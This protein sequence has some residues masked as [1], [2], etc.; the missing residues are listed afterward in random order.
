MIPGNWVSISSGLIG[1]GFG[2]NRSSLMNCGSI[3]PDYMKARNRWQ[4]CRDIVEGEDVVRSR[5]TLYLPK[6]SGQD[7]D[8]YTAY[9]LRASFTNGTGRAVDGLEGLIYRKKPTSKLPTRTDKLAADITTTGLTLDE[10]AKHVT[11]DV[12]KT[13]RGGLLVEFPTVKP[14]PNKVVAEA[15]S[16]GERP[17]ITYFPT[18]DILNWR[19]GKIKNKKQLTWLKL[20]DWLETANVDDP[21]ITEYTE[22]IIE[23]S[24]TPDGKCVQYE[25][26]GGRRIGGVPK[27]KPLI[28]NNEPLTYI[29]FVFVGSVDT[30]STV[31]K[32]LIYDIAVKN[33]HHWQLSADLRHALHWVDNPTPVVIGTI[34]TPDGRPAEVVKLGSSS[35]LNV[36]TGGDTK[37]LEMM[38]NGLEP[39]SKQMDRD[40][41][42]MAILLSRI[43]SGDSKAAE[44]AETAAI[45]RA[46]ENAVL[47]SFANAIS[48]AI[49]KAL[50][51]V[52]TWLKEDPT[53]VSYRLNT[54]FYPTPMTSQMLIALTNSLI[55]KAIS[56][57]EFFDTLIAGDVVRADK[58]IDEHKEEVAKMPDAEVPKGGALNAP[59]GADGKKNNGPNADAGTGS[60]EPQ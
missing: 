21:G 15:E 34:V 8:E 18:E 54:N 26:V 43:L 48:G 7:V 46:G 33:V 14:D 27:V 3:H 28:I 40:L 30:S 49:T 22:V 29:P 17:Y 60:T 16:N 41:A 31:Q 55:A 45:H 10:L 6:P 11:H 59:G 20:R 58:T 25:Y 56:P 51:I 32:P 38:G 53:E 44:A 4:L 24:L 13:S 42:E 23:L 47:A 50:Q 39:T 37:M 57:E 5:G 35:V 36:A 2:I 12:L 9:S 1:S 52:A 19:E